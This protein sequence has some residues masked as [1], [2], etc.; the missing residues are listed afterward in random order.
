MRFSIETEV[1]ED[2]IPKDKNRA[3]MSL[4]KS[5][6]E[7]YDKNLYLELYDK[8]KTFRKDYSFSLYM[9]NSKFLR[10]EILVP[11]KKILINISTSD[12]RL[13]VLFYNA[14]LNSKG[15]PYKIKENEITVKNIR[16]VKEKDIFS[17]SVILK[18]M[19]PIVVREHSGDNRLTWYHSLN[20][21]K[22]RSIFVQN[23]KYQLLDRFGYER[24]VD[25][26]NI[27]VE[28][29][30]NREVKV[31]HYGIEVLSNICILR[32]EAQPY[33][34]DY[35]YKAGLSSMKSAGFGLLDIY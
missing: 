25:I 32:I 35:I 7:S 2:K 17:E 29:L 20:E 21:E 28:I 9:P 11:D 4:F 24:E 33:I 34:L 13:G 12:S 3:V 27:S 31:K 15:K 23:L 16:M 6:F 10:E 14:F 5:I 19:S 30:S 26:D 22:G 1:K 8:D 18:T